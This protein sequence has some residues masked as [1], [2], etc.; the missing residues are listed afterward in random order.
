MME[1]T[2]STGLQMHAQPQTTMRRRPKHVAPQPRRVG[3]YVAVPGFIGWGDAV[4]CAYA[5]VRYLAHGA[6]GETWE[7]R[8]TSTG[9]RYAMKIMPLSKRSAASLMRARTEVRCM[10][11]VDYFACI[12]LHDK[13]ETD[14]YLFL[15]M[16]YC[17][18]GDLRYQVRGTSRLHEHQITY[19][20]LQLVL[21]L[22][23]MHTQ[24]KMLHRDL[25]PANVLLTT[26][27]LVK[28]GD[29]GLS[30][31]YDSISGD[32]GSTICG[33]PAYLAPELWR[34]ERYGAAADMWSL[35]IVLYEAMTGRPPFGGSCEA[36]RH[37]VLNEEVPP[38]EAPYS[39][40]LKEIVHSLLRKSP[41][42]RPN[43]TQLLCKPFIASALENFP[44]VLR[45]S[46][47][48]DHLLSRV[49]HD[50][51]LVQ[52]AARPCTNDNVYFAGPVRKVKHADLY[53]DRYMELQGNRLS[54]L[55]GP[56]AAVGQRGCIPVQDVEQVVLIDSDRFAL[57]TASTDWTLFETPQAAEWDMWLR[58]AMYP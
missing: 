52:I 40:A 36:L 50:L 2:T 57:K 42:E 55:L 7:I 49:L 16:E 48:P 37:G 39:P 51:S 17:D 44:N 11:C 31:T 30:N 47:V 33:T 24:R 5:Y 25:K 15:V 18:A 41:N 1:N 54:L 23:Y 46:C 28:V 22:H 38:I 34:N 3:D 43:T 20:A 27:G 35:G 29:F 32:V 6:S 56:G 21:G 53:S 58:E 13:L 9:V 45:A 10:E 26:N 12:R 19:I 8:S 4:G 14:D